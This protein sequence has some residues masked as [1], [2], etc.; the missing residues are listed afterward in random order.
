MTK[1][2]PIQLSERAKE[3]IKRANL[4]WVSKEKKQ[5]PMGHPWKKSFFRKKKGQVKT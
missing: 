3:K 1:S 2:T 5:Q 4:L